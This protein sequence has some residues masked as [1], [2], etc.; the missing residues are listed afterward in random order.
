MGDIA[1]GFYKEKNIF[2]HILF[3][4]LEIHYYHQFMELDI[5]F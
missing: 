2:G 1:T 3:P 5:D 4:L